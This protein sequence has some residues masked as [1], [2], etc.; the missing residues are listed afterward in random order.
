MS[1]YLFFFDVASFFHSLIYKGKQEKL[2]F[3]LF[4][5]QPFARIV[6]FIVSKDSSTKYCE[7][8]G[9]LYTWVAAMETQDDDACSLAAISLLMAQRSLLKTM[10]KKR[11]PIKS[12]MTVFACYFAQSDEV[13]TSY[14][15]GRS[16]TPKLFAHT[17]LD[18]IG[19]SSLQN[20]FILT[21]NHCLLPTSY[22]NA[23]I[24]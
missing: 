19:S 14:L 21:T 1:S 10:Y 2:K 13:A 4:C 17:A 8:F 20:D 12:G 23:A 9:R 5:N 18:S 7:K 16:P 22:C 11:S 3:G 6:F 15:K 24:L